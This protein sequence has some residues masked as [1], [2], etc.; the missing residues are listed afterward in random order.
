MHL[1]KIA[2]IETSKKH[3]E[4]RELQ[5]VSDWAGQSTDGRVFFLIE[6]LTL[7]QR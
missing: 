5:G 7:A 3:P 1:K 4:R 6:K 2:L